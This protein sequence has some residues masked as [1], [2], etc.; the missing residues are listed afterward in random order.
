MLLFT[1]FVPIFLFCCCFFCFF[2]FCFLFFG[3]E[4]FLNYSSFVPPPPPFRYQDAAGNPAASVEHEEVAYVGVVTILPV[5]HVPYYLGTMKERFPIDFTITEYA[6]SNTVH[7]TFI[8]MTGD[9]HGIRRVFLT[10]EFERPGRY[11]FTMEALS[12]AVSTMPQVRSVSNIIELDSSVVEGSAPNLLSGSLYRVTINYQDRAGNPGVD[13][14]GNSIEYGTDYSSDILVDLIPPQVGPYV[15]IDLSYGILRVQTLELVSIN[16]TFWYGMIFGI[17]LGQLYLSDTTLSNDISMSAGGTL[18]PDTFDT[19]LK[20]AR[21]GTQNV[22]IQMTEEQRIAAILKSGTPGGDGSPLVL[23]VYAAAL[24]DLAGN[25]NLGQPNVSIVES[26][27]IIPPEVNGAIIHLGNGTIIIT[28]GEI[29]DANPVE[30]VDLSKMTLMNQANVDNVAL[31]VELA[32]ATVTPEHALQVTL[33]LTEL[34]RAAAIEISNTPGGDGTV[35]LL[36]CDSGSLVDVGTNPSVV[37]NNV[38]VVE[39]PDVILPAITSVT[40]NFGTGVLVITH[41]TEIMDLTP[42]SSKIFLEKLF[43]SDDSTDRAVP[44]FGARPEESDAPE[45]TVI[46]T[47]TQR[48]AA[49]VSSGTPGGDGVAI[50]MNTDEGMTRDIGQ[51]NLPALDDIT[52]VETPDT[53]I[54]IITSAL[55]D[56]NDGRLYFY[57][58]ETIHANP[59]SNVALTQCHLEN[60]L[61][62]LHLPL[63]D[64]NGRGVAT[65]D[66]A[67]AVNV[68]IHLTLLQRAEAVRISNTPGGD[69]SVLTI[70]LGVAFVRDMAGNTNAATTP[71]SVFEIPDTTR[72]IL[73]RAI[74]NYSTGILIMHVNEIMELTN[75]GTID[76][77]HLYLVQSS[78]ESGGPAHASLTYYDGTGT[79][80]T[81][82]LRTH[83]GVR[84]GGNTQE[85]GDDKVLEIKMSEEQRIASLVLSGTPGGD[86]TGLNLSVA[87][88]AFA[89]L[90]GNLIVPIDV[91]LEEHPDTLRPSIVS[92]SL[93]LTQGTLTLG[94]SETIDFT[95]TS[96][97]VLSNVIIA[98]VTGDNDVILGGGGTGG[99]MGRSLGNFPG[100]LSAS[101]VAEAEGLTI[102][103]TLTESQRVRCIEISAT[104]GGDGSATVLDVAVGAFVDMAGNPNLPSTNFLNVE[105]ED[106]SLPSITSA[107]IFLGTGI[108]QVT[109]D[110]TI[111]VTPTTY[112]NQTGLIIDN[113]ATPNSGASRWIRLGGAQIPFG[114]KDGLVFTIQMSESQRVL[115]IALS[116]TPGGDNLAALLDVDQGAVR[117]VAGNFVAIDSNNAMTEHADSIIPVVESARVNYS[118]G[119]VI[120]RSS[121][122]I[123]TTPVSKVDLDG[124][125]LV[126]KST[127]SPSM[128]VLSGADI[129]ASDAIFTTIQLTESQR[130]TAI[131]MS[132]TPGGDAESNIMTFMYSSLLDIATNPISE[133]HD[134]IVNETADTIPPWT[135]SATLDYNNGKLVVTGSETIDSTPSSGHVQPQLFF[136]LNDNEVATTENLIVNLLPSTTVT[137]SDGLTVTLTLT[138][139]QRIRTLEISNTPGGDGIDA[140]LLETKY[141]AFQDVAVN[142]SLHVTNIVVIETA[143]TTAPSGVQA[144][145]DLNNGTLRIFFDETIDSTPASTQINP[146][147]MLLVDEDGGEANL[148]LTG[149]DVVELD[150]VVVTLVLT[151]LQR[152]KAIE[153]GGTPGGDSTPLH[154]RLGYQATRDIGQNYNQQSWQS[155]GDLLVQETADTTPPVLEAAL[156]NLSDGRML[157]TFSETIDSTPSADKVNTNDVVFRNADNG[158]EIL[159]LTGSFVISDDQLTL[160]LTMDEEKRVLSI[161]NSGEPGGDTTPMVLHTTSLFVHDI[162]GVGMV[163]IDASTGGF[164]INEIADT[165]RPNVV[166]GEIN[167][168]TGV[169][170]LEHTE[171]VDSTPFSNVVLDKYSFL[172]QDGATPAVQLAGADTTEHDSYNFTITLTER[173]RIDSIQISGTQGGPSDGTA[174]SVRVLDYAF[175]DIA[176]NRNPHVQ[177]I[178]L[179]ETPDTTPPVPLSAT[180]NYGTG[181]LMFNTSEI[182][183][184]TPTTKLQLANL[185]IRND[186]TIVVTRPRL[187]GFVTSD[188]ENLMDATI[189]AYDDVRTIVRLTELQRVHAIAFSST[190]GGDGAS[191]AWLILEIGAIVDVATNVNPSRYSLL[192]VEE[193]DII[194][195]NLLGATINYGSGIL[196]ITTDEIIDVTPYK[197]QVNLIKFYINSIQGSELS[198]NNVGGNGVYVST[199]LNAAVVDESDGQ[200]LTIQLTELQ[201]VK[202]LLT[203]GTPGGD[204]GVNFLDVAQGG[205]VDIAQNPSVTIALTLNE[206][207]DVSAPSLLSGRVNLSDGVVVLLGTEILDVRTSS[208]SPLNT[209]GIYL[210]D[211]SG[212]RSVHLQGCHLHLQEDRDFSHD[213]TLTLTE[214]QRVALIAISNTPGGDAE[215]SVLDVHTLTVKDMAGNNNLDSFNL[216]MNETADD[217]RPRVVSA[218]INYGVGTVVLGF[219]ETINYGT[220]D[221]SKVMLVDSNGGDGTTL[222][223]LTG[224]TILAQN[225]TPRYYEQTES[226]HHVVFVL[227]E[228]TRSLAIAQSDTSGGDGTSMA[229]RFEEEFIQDMAT[230]N[231]LPPIST[232]IL[233]DF[234]LI[235]TPDTLRPVVSAGFLNY[236]TG[237][238]RIFTNE[239]LDMTPSSSKVNLNGF[240]LHDVGS[241]TIIQL[242]GARVLD[243]DGLSFDITLNEE[244]RAI[245][246]SLSN[247]PGGTTNAPIR[248]SIAAGSFVDVAQNHNVEVSSLA[249]SEAPDTLNPQLVR[250]DLDLSDGTMWIRWD[251][252]MD[253]TPVSG[254][255]VVSL[256]SLVNGTMGE[257]SSHDGAAIVLA[258]DTVVTS[259]EDGYYVNVTLNEEQRIRAVEYSGTIGGDGMANNLRCRVGAVHDVGENANDDRTML[260]HEYQDTVRPFVTLATIDYNNGYFVVNTSERINLEAERKGRIYAPP[261]VDP[262]K[263]FI[264]NVSGTPQ[265]DLTQANQLIFVDGTSF[266]YKLR[267]IDRVVAMMRSGTGDS[268]DLHPIV[269]DIDNDAIFDVAHNGNLQLLNFPVT[270]IEDTTSPNFLHAEIHLSEGLLFLKF[271]EVMELATDGSIDRY[272]IWLKNAG[273]DRYNVGADVHGTASS[274]VLGHIMSSAF[275][276]GQSMN[277]SLP[278]E[279]RVSSIL[280]SGTSGGDGTAMMIELDVGAVKDVSGNLNVLVADGLLFEYPDVIRPTILFGSINYSTGFIEIT[281][282]E[283]MDVTPISN[284]NRSSFSLIGGGVANVNVMSL[285]LGH[286][287]LATDHLNS[288][289]ASN[290]YQQTRDGDTS[291]FGMWLEEDQRILALLESGQ[292]GGTDINNGPLRLRIEENAY[293]DVATNPCNAVPLLLLTEYPDTIRPYPIEVIIEYDIG[294]VTLRFSEHVDATPQASMNTGQMHISNTTYGTELRMVDLVSFDET[295]GINVTLYI[296]EIY[297]NQGLRMSGVKG[298]DGNTAFMNFRPSSFRDMAGNF[299]D[300]FFS[301]PMTEIPDTRPPEIIGSELFYGTGLLFIHFSESIDVTPTDM[302]NVS[303]FYISNETKL[304]EFGTIHVEGGRVTTPITDNSTFSISLTEEQRAQAVRMSGTPGGDVGSIILDV[305]AGTVYDLAGNPNVLFFHVVIVE[306]EDNVPPLILSSM[307][308]LST[309]HLIIQS[310]ETMDTTP[311]STDPLAP[312]NASRIALVNSEFNAVAMETERTTPGVTNVL[313]NLDGAQ[314][315]QCDGHP[316][317]CDKVYVTIV[318]T[319]RQRVR[320]I[321]MS[322]TPGGDG[323]GMTLSLLK[324]AVRDIALNFQNTTHNVI[325]NETA[326][327]IR[328]NTL[329]ATLNYSNG[330]LTIFADETVDTTPTSL[331]HPEF[332][333]FVNDNNVATTSSRVQ[334]INAAQVQISPDGLSFSMILTEY[335]RFRVLEM[336]DTPGGDGTPVLLEI[337]TGGYF[338]IGQNSNEHETQ[339]IVT[340]HRDSVHPELI[341]AWLDLN[342]GTLRVFFSET[343]DS[344]PI[345]L[346]TQASFLLVNQAGVPSTSDLVLSSSQVLPADGLSITLVLSELERVRAIERSATPGGDETPLHLALLASAVHDIGT[347]PSLSS[348]TAG[349][350]VAETADTTIPLALSATLDLG[351]AVLIITCN[352]YIDSTPSTLIDT[353]YLHISNDTTWHRWPGAGKSE[354]GLPLENLPYLTGEPNANITLSGAAVIAHDGVN[355]TL[356]LTEAMRVG[357]LMFSGVPFVEYGD[358]VNVGE[359]VIP[360][361]VFMDIGQNRQTQQF[362]LPLLEF[363]DRVRPS[364]IRVVIDFNDGTLDFYP[365]ET[366]HRDMNKIDITKIW[367]TNNTLGVG[368]T[369][370]SEGYYRRFSLTDLGGILSGPTLLSNGPSAAFRVQLN[371]IQRVSALRFSNTSGGDL[372]GNI[373]VELEAHAVTDLSLNT[374][375]AQDS[376]PS[377]EIPD[378]TPPGISATATLH[379]GTGTLSVAFSETV[380]ASKGTGIGGVD[381]SKIYLSNSAGD[382]NFNILG[383]YVPPID[384]LSFQVTLSESVRVL[385][386]ALS[387][388][389]GGDSV[390]LLLETLPLGIYDVAGNGNPIQSVS[391]LT[392]IADTIPPIPIGASINFGTGVII[393]NAS[394][395]IDTTPFSLLDLN[396]IFVSQA[397]NGRDVSLIGDST[398]PLGPVETR[399]DAIAVVAFDTTSFT[400]TMTEAMRVSSVG[401]SNSAGLNGN[402]AGTN[403]IVDILTNAII[404]VAQNRNPA[405]VGL[406]VIEIPDTVRPTVLDA[407][408][409]YG[410]GIVHMY[411]SEPIDATSSSGFVGVIHQNRILFYEDNTTLL[412][413]LA[414]GV[415]NQRDNSIVEIDLHESTRAV[416]LQHSATLG[417]DGS[418]L[419]L[420]VLD[421]AMY[422]L[423]NNPSLLRNPFNLTE[424]A[425]TIPPTVLSITLDFN[426]GNLTLHMSETMDATPPQGNCY[427]SSTWLDSSASYGCP[428]SWLLDDSALLELIETPGSRTNLIKLKSANPSAGQHLAV[429]ES[430]DGTN[431]RLLLNEQA[432]VAALLQSGTPG[433]DGDALR[434]TVGRF[435]AHDLARN[436]IISADHVAFIVTEIP[437][438]VKPLV[439]YAE[440]HLDNGTV[441]IWM[442]ETLRLVPNSLMNSTLIRF[443]NLAETATVD[444]ATKVTLHDATM[445]YPNRNNGALVMTLPEDQRAKYIA[446]SG[447]SGG[448]GGTM[449]LEMLPDAV[450]DMSFNKNNM[451][452]I[453]NIIEHPDEVRPTIVHGKLH[454]S[455]GELYFFSVFLIFLAFL[456]LIFSHGVVSLSLSLSLTHTHIHFHSLT[457]SARYAGS[458]CLRDY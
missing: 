369:V 443:S 11:N 310:S 246:V 38:V 181:Y 27:D 210:S 323:V 16:S 311:T 322:A 228:L 120:V 25:P 84:L 426:T 135:V 126:N 260:V 321:A 148:P 360:P 59:S 42:A 377:T 353:T 121:E 46:L 324:F 286:S 386:I 142:P 402:N 273:G 338:D 55:L 328:P 124:I 87:S 173:Q 179:V 198:D 350:L 183:D 279:I 445:D 336:S 30:N 151:E 211:V 384:L 196:V 454:L 69:G 174:I 13:E 218:T 441:F 195:P 285:E 399:L 227:D 280:R 242:T 201:R 378:T 371:E 293:F 278:E 132:G 314:Y 398:F 358:Q 6:L 57:T 410:T 219:S 298:G 45:L 267:E 90:A 270:E 54:P 231:L 330:L 289:V 283:T 337:A 444:N 47:E 83:D 457:Y 4:F 14:N 190:R 261:V 316:M 455:N 67:D 275:V 18:V 109:A 108:L 153:R 251:E 78:V 10:S 230:N 5:L 255:V 114:K 182:I 429:P 12:T 376:I 73:M 95:P 344:T 51:N 167:Y 315:I 111:D 133:T 253:L 192:L 396:L 368:D 212:D 40:L 101:V 187:N 129:A 301:I 442:T 269:L 332:F 254:N 312:L 36:S 423:Y 29:A 112:V 422:D 152:V 319:E 374:N 436:W 345:S 159:R 326:D 294:K 342:N 180:I 274:F 19:R 264:S 428:G 122:T 94:F 418:F 104:S 420:S 232:G 193:D 191:A 300:Q 143:D 144:W 421:S 244:Q 130:V 406:S 389:P 74:V 43:L 216:Q 140:V 393:V 91:V 403:A 106:S 206:I 417:G 194:P 118:T 235:E 266:M 258:T 334:N 170:I 178:V 340:E 86:G 77:T 379:Y 325:V 189:T 145:L 392:E 414:A 411:M 115:A 432:R 356:T 268:G 155:G 125:Y 166:G 9:S 343:I 156:L 56:L 23:D 175:H 401:L 373:L 224:S 158:L 58:S 137:E 404:D 259:T 248:L 97:L 375:E 439:A 85:T 434:L 263:L 200:S 203:S 102:V 382:L 446:Q 221:L 49:L 50:T 249:L 234:L 163:P 317:D 204:G 3:F 431:L 438:E 63:D 70:K 52:V 202:S 28:L 347:N 247:T 72:P 349:V 365:S 229:I 1:F 110:E 107:E 220:L 207:G 149:A 262:S 222:L 367:L 71:I 32:G 26:P 20:H 99:T 62:D 257:V 277:I 177:D 364:L 354:E 306:H 281:S 176:Q 146:S 341:T 433:G 123:D 381:V 352:E 17:N 213:F 252:T 405:D 383:A 419:M 453:S 305:L 452:I 233:G 448:D 223:S 359:L 243:V 245:A 205:F 318:L 256:L 240:T 80:G 165:I 79:E 7:L 98:N 333:S 397:V 425:D 456:L 150:R 307:L 385:A 297:R 291:I 24:K 88:A 394:E 313:I 458:F 61:N 309:G 308:N 100:D 276:H 39:H 327:T 188:V 75:D 8:P 236:T 271:D 287:V 22:T 184:V 154:L 103:V 2:V 160:T 131:A 225:L 430:I 66:V 215:P 346:V 53:I 238:L 372:S 366:L 208:G 41:G 370:T 21:Y 60:N 331:I 361:G 35:M 304:G 117:D 241:S 92:S 138:E 15:T 303:G 435:F 139:L 162:A 412:I 119:I 427:D 424:T 363:S 76:S 171:T 68:T 81:Y 355:I 217:V 320:A 172:A 449:F 296:R 440:I 65:V 348:A 82:Q 329:S 136:L 197:T 302:V 351:T 416:A 199:D 128:V 390:P 413:D 214:R 339:I 161:E 451:Q 186:S 37:N 288:Y 437:D 157:F 48:I 292:P 387:G 209:T 415:L 164:V 96:L 127:T 407:T 89:D 239:T 168:D 357:A 395:T 408:I 335:E 64:A 237:L 388:T 93:D 295:D 450:Q 34:Q 290:A 226:R 299:N 33:T 250:V 409:N 447:T 44:L 31:D 272:K 282:D 134:V 284:V 116:G 400:I 265:F 147:A 362:I 185:A 141:G 169:M 391:V 113:F 105:I 380:A